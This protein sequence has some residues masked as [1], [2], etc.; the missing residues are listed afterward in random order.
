MSAYKRFFYM[1]RNGDLAPQLID[2]VVEGSDGERG[3]F[4]GKTFAELKTKYPELEVCDKEHFYDLA[5]QAARTPP[6]VIPQ[7]EFDDLLGCL[8]PEDFVK[9]ARDTESFKLCEYYTLDVT[10][11]CARI[12]DQYFKLRDRADMSH[13][14]ILEAISRSGLLSQIDADNECDSPSP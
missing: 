2:P 10:I 3:L 5:R 9:G 1:P 7:K 8:P 14:D 4:S 12:G 13:E 6:E 11:I